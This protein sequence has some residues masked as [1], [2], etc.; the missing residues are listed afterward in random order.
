VERRKGSRFNLSLPVYLKDGKGI[1]RNI[2]SSGILFETDKPLS[3]GEVI[4]LCVAFQDSTIQ[5]EGRVVR[6]EK[7]DGQSAVALEFRSCVFN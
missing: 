2:S 6:V 1:T 5:C 4:P 7:G 3:L